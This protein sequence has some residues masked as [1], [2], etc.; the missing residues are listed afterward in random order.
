MVS[1]LRMF[2]VEGF[3]R[4]SAWEKALEKGLGPSGQGRE[5]PELIGTLRGEYRGENRG[6]CVPV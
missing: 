1:F 6:V 2:D 3:S 5:K 4:I